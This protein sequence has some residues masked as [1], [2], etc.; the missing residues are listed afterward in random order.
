MHIQRW[1]RYGAMV[2]LAVSVA[3]C[4]DTVGPAGEFDPEQTA[5]ALQEM[6]AA[7]DGEEM[8]HAMGSVSAASDLFNSATTA[9]LVAEPV[10]PSVATLQGLG[11]LAAADIFPP[12]LP[13]GTTFVW[14]EV[15]QSYV[16][17]EMTGAP[18]DGI[19]IVYYAVDPFT[20]VPASPLNPLGYVDLRDLSTVDSDRLAVMVVSTS[21]D[22]DVTLADY[23]L[24]LAYTL[25]QSSLTIDV[26]GVGYL[27]NGVDQLNFDVSQQLSGT[28]TEINLSQEYSLDLEGT[29][30]AVSFT[31]SM[32]VDP[33]SQS[34][35]PQA[36]DAVAVIEGNGQSVRLELSWDGTDLGGA[37][38][39]NNA[40]VVMIAG[41]L[42]QPTFSSA[43]DEPLTQ[44]QVNALQSV[45]SAIGEIFE[46]VDGVF[47]VGA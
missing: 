33:Q 24:D 44:E 15:E 4:E 26:E 12:E 40:P 34:G 3:A 17:G 19:R 8:A 25:T 29:D 27:S 21:G 41:T 13:L 35:D 36:M 37:L 9:A 2:M 31:A 39:Y 22:T 18:A 28:D 23:Y 45:W 6:A 7:V 5:Q 11:G 46:F 14:S 42:D 32:T 1:T 16:A 10:N 43:N 47:S 38:Y 30:K 20:G